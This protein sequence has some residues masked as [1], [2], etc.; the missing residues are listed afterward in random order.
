[1]NDMATETRTVDLSQGTIRYRETGTGEPIV[2]VHGFLVDGRLW[3]GAAERLRGD[4]R[5]ILPDWP[6]GSHAIAME[7]H[8]DL[9]PPGMARIVADFLAAL[10]LEGVTV[11]GN[12][13]GGAISQILVTHH[14]ERIGRLVL[15]N[16]DT[17]E[18]F[19]P[20]PFGQF[21][22]IVRVPGVMTAMT[23]PLRIGAMRRAAFRPFARTRVPDDLLR[24]W[25]EPSAT[26]GDVR[27]DARKFAMGMDKRHTLEAAER[28]SGTDLPVLL[29]W[30]PEDRIFPLSYAERLAQAIPN[31]RIERIPGAKTFVA[32]DQPERL[33]DA[34]ASFVRETSPTPAG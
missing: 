21:P 27:R 8:A 20:S 31:A 12:D 23:L 10:D 34:I 30:A 24:A 26:H 9:S 22:R 7:P 18:N 6:M 2:F 17:H 32:L 15:T 29:A 25:V 1:M 11:V 13:S 16:C 3:D 19:P 4:F 5:C 28:L 14:P 33:A